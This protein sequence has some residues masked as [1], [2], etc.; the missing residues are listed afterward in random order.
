M[1]PKEDKQTEKHTERQTGHHYAGRHE[2][3]C[4]RWLT[5]R[6]PHP[7]SY[8]SGRPWLDVGGTDVP[9]SPLEAEVG[10]RVPVLFTGQV[11]LQVLLT[12]L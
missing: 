10:G 1:V 8:L 4:T 2:V 9:C 12:E 3:R 7:P 6:P 5:A 11:E